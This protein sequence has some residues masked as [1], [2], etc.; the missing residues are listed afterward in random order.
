MLLITE[1]NIYNLYA[2]N[3]FSH[4]QES[5]CMQ[6]KMLGKDF[7]KNEGQSKPCIMF[8]LSTIDCADIREQINAFLLI[9]FWTHDGTAIWVTPIYTIYINAICIISCG[10]VR[11]FC[12]V[13]EL[14]CKFPQSCGAHAAAVVYYA[15]KI[16]IG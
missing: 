2:L 4:N 1:Q 5:F 9:F 3:I 14:C 7:T 15:M 11:A 10:S 6:F 13:S 16:P 8:V 12:N